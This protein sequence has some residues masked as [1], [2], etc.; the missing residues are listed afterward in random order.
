MKLKSALQQFDEQAERLKAA[1]RQSLPCLNKNISIEGDKVPPVP[2]K[3]TRD[4]LAKQKQI[5]E[6]T[7]AHRKSAYALELNVKAFIDRWGLEHVGFLTLTFEEHIT[8]PKEAQRRFNSL[9]TNYLRHHYAHYIRVFERQKTG[10]IHYHL[11]VACTENIRRGLNF[12]QI[13]ARDYSSANPAIRRHWKNL[14][15][16]MSKYG[17]GRSEL[18]PIKTNSKGL[19]RYVAKYIGKHIDARISADKGVRLCQTSQDKAARW[20]VATSNFQFSSPGSKL[21]RQKLKKW[22]HEMDC[23]FFGS[24]L[25][26]GYFRKRTDYIPLTEDNYSERLTQLLGSKWAY[27]NRETIAAMPL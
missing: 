23:Y 7:T 21:W 13:A 24:H 6:F 8:D 1:G 20:K 16:A 18:L 22:V 11:L 4:N 15:A 14:R 17:F 10:R 19:A 9:R 27:C 5:N 26:G 12:R 3:T 25:T 2:C